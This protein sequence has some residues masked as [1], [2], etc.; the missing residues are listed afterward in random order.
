VSLLELNRDASVAKAGIDGQGDV[1][2]F[3]QLPTLAPE[4]LPHAWDQLA[5]LLHAVEDLDQSGTWRQRAR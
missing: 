1:V 3:Y 2:L 4:G 5:G